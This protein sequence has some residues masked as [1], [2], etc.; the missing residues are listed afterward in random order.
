[1]NFY[2]KVYGG[3]NEKIYIEILN[4]FVGLCYSN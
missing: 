2:F 1:M 4:Y 3:I